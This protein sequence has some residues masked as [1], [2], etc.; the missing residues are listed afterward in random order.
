MLCRKALCMLTSSKSFLAHRYRC[1]IPPL[2]VARQRQDLQHI[3][4]LHLG[5]NRNSRH[6]MSLIRPLLTAVAV[7]SRRQSF[8]AIAC[9]LAL[10]NPVLT[11]AVSAPSLSLASPAFIAPRS[12]SPRSSLTTRAMSLGVGGSGPTLPDAARHRPATDLTFEAGPEFEPEATVL[13]GKKSTLTDLVADPASLAAVLKIDETSL[14]LVVAAFNSIS[15]KSGSA[16]T[17]VPVAGGG[18]VHRVGLVTVPDSVT[19]NNHPLSVHSITGALQKVTPSKGDVRVVVAPGKAD[20]GSAIVPGAVGLLVAKAFPIFSRKTSDGKPKTA[21][22]DRTV[23]V[24]LLDGMLKPVSDGPSIAAMAA[25]ADGTRLAARLVDTPPEELTTA[26]FAAEARAVAD[27]LGGSVTYS[28]I[29]GDELRERGYGGLHGVGRAAVVP[30][31]LVTLTYE[32]EGGPTDGTRTVALVGKGIV[33]D[34]GG[35]ALKSKTGMVGMK[36]DM[37]GAAG[38]LG[39]F[40]TAAA[41]G[42]PHRIHLILCLAENAIGPSAFRNDDILN[43]YS[44]KTVEINNTDAEGRLVLADGVA[45]ATR[46]IDGLDLVVD[47]ATLTGAQLVATGKKHAG[48]LAN[49][50]EL[51]GRAVRAGL[52]SGDFVF[53]LLYAPELLKSE[54][55]SDVADMKNSVKDRGNAQTSCAGHFIEDHLHPDYEGEYLHVD[56][57]GP[58][59]KGG[60]GTGYGVGLVNSLLKSKGF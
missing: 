37:G 59:D 1:A 60:R 28:E 56:M 23:A 13:V 49:T 53:P 31:R 43:M 7:A 55:Q 34:T 19:R 14:P 10:T 48:I 8:A 57:A 24:T 12:S 52:S 3:P 6:H 40:Y 58:A 44:G 15:G 33:Y 41:L 42:S 5:S 4:F 35:L 21:E 36:T 22:D 16:A 26:A 17:F 38:V 45:H 32:P 54:F 51:E 29:V 11:S 27:A 47:M 50:I 9:T 39:A 18:G 30:P 25:A 20:G 2:L 46:H